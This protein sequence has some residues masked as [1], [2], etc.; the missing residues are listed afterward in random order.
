MVKNVSKSTSTISIL[1][2]DDERASRD[3]LRNALNRPDRRIVIAQDGREAVNM[4]E[5]EAFDVVVTDLN[6]PG[7]NGIEVFRYAV[8]AGETTQVIFITGYGSL[9]MVVGA[10]EDGA[11]DF[12]A[13]PFKL[14]EIQLVVRNACDKVRLMKEVQQLRAEL[15]TR[16]DANGAIDRT[17][18]VAGISGFPSGG[19]KAGFIGEYARAAEDAWLQADARLALE[20]LRT[21]GQIS[22]AEF[23]LLE[24]R[25]QKSERK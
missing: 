16:S 19:G 18:E 7:V 17:A 5:I 3:L 10:I 1:V 8:G 23:A 9:E 21:G 14:A 15:A 2:A 20:R 22:A 11:Y 6:M 25:L 4:L 13:K 24:E 12:V